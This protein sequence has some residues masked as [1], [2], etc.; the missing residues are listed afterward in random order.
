MSYTSTQVI[1]TPS[2]LNPLPIYC[3]ESFP[4]K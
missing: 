1:F 3:R 2:H 4:T